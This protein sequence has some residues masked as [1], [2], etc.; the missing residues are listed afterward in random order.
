MA[1]VL[2][3][4]GAVLATARV[5]LQLFAHAQ[6]VLA[7][8]L[9]YYGAR[10]HVLL[11]PIALPADADER[12]RAHLVPLYQLEVAALYE[13]QVLRS[14]VRVEHPDFGVLVRAKQPQKAFYR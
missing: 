12:G 8:L 13:V 6:L 9:E 2:L 11:A 10:E 5:E 7:L 14:R 4:T 1:L 3:A